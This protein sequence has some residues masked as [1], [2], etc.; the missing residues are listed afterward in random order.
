MRA[1]GEINCKAGSRN[2]SLRIGDELRVPAA[3]GKKK[4]LPENWQHLSR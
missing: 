4:V 1:K 2:F 3:V